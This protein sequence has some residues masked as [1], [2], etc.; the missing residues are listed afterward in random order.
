MTD[1][2]IAVSSARNT[3]G[4]SPR[5]KT[6]AV[7]GFGAAEYWSN[8]HFSGSYDQ[9]SKAIKQWMTKETVD[10][11][12]TDPARILWVNVSS[13]ERR[14]QRRAATLSLPLQIIDREFVD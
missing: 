10:Y 8:M 14:L 13:A 12:D 2:W 1:F 9:V 6:P 11:P 7:T 5:G 4:A 3:W